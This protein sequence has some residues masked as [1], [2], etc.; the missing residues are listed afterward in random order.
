[1]KLRTAYFCMNCDEEVSIEGAL[2]VFKCPWCG[3]RNAWGLAGVYE[4]KVEISQSEIDKANEILDALACK[5]TL[6]K[7]LNL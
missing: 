7:K 4:W 5:R 2:H 3:Y 6:E 1:M